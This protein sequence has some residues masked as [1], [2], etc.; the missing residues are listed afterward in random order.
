MIIDFDQIKQDAMKHK[1]Q[2]HCREFEDYYDYCF[3][4]D[5]EEKY[6][7]FQVHSVQVGD[8]FVGILEEKGRFVLVSVQFFKER[9]SVTRIGNWIDKMG[10]HLEEHVCM[11]VDVSNASKIVAG[12]RFKGRP[13]VVYE[14][15][16]QTLRYDLSDSVEVSDIYKS[17]NSIVNPASRNEVEVDPPCKA[18][19]FYDGERVYSVPRIEFDLSRDVIISNGQVIVAD[20]IEDYCGTIGFWQEDNAALPVTFFYD[21]ETPIYIN[22]RTRQGG[23]KVCVIEQDYKVQYDE[24]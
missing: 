24:L 21:D 4:D 20:Y 17:Y 15:G 19:I 10:I 12:L 6:D 14:K 5:Y 3:V 2:S 18:T 8:V 13:L 16:Q 1:M 11:S 23:S 7:R 22:I 9:F